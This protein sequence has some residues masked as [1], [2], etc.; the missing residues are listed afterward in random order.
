[1]RPSDL[2][3]PDDLSGQDRVRITLQDVEESLMMPLWSRAKLTK[4]H[5]PLISD[6]KAVE[7]VNRIDYDFSDLDRRFPFRN[8][9]LNV[10]R[11]KHFDDKIRS[12]TVMHPH[13]S[14][15]N[16]GAGLDTTFYRIDN[17]LIQWYDL[18]LP[19]VIELRRKLIPESDRV[20]SISSSMFEPLWYESIDR[21]QEGIFATSGG[22]LIYHNESEVKSF[23]TKFADNLPGAEIVFDALSRLGAFLANRAI[24]KTGIKKAVVRWALKDAN[25]I[26]RWDKRLQ[27]VDQFPFFRGIPRRMGEGNQEFHG[28]HRQVQDLQYCA[29]ESVTNH[30]RAE[31]V[32]RM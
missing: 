2:A 1:M 20:C 32:I 6:L 14:I 18:D 31:P 28:Y 30:A 13:A 24:R 5:S 12:F 8:N 29:S 27:V 22:V 23:L 16:I 21:T 4:E 9:L 3:M 11:A 25:V 15:I 19:N 26:S 17:G 7:I 10:A